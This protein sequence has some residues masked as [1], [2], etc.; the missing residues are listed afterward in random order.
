MNKSLETHASSLLHD[1]QILLCEAESVV[2][3]CS[4]CKL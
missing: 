3:S 4:D 2:A 1:N